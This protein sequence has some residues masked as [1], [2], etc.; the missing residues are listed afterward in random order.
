MDPL[1]RLTDADLRSLA[2]ALR[3]GRLAPPFAAVGVGRVVSR[4]LAADLTERMQALADEG[5]RAEH[6]AVLAEAVRAATFSLISGEAS[7]RSRVRFRYQLPIPCQL[8]NSF[9]TEP[10]GGKKETT[11][12]PATPC[13]GGISSSLRIPSMFER[14]QSA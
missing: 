5:M 1:Q 2:A 10:P 9:A 12:W 8:A 14:V 7:R 13:R 11:I 4:P 6:I 3:A